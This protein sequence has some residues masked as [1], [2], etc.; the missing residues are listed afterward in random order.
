M[1]RKVKSI[2]ILC[3]LILLF[4]VILPP[5]VGY[6]ENAENADDAANIENTDVAEN[7]SESEEAT[8]TE[9]AVMPPTS[10]PTETE[11]SD[12]DDMELMASNEY[13]ELY[14]NEKNAEF[15]VKEKEN[16]YIWY[17]NPAERANDPIAN[18][19]NKSFLSA[20]IALTYFNEKGQTVKFDTYKDSVVEEQFEFEKIDNG[21]KVVY[22]LGVEAKGIEQI[23]EKIS[24][25]RF[26][27]LILDKLSEDDR[28][29]IEKRFKFVEEEDLYERR[30]GAFS[31]LT[32]ARTLQYFEEVGYTEEDLAFDNAEH[33]AADAELLAYPNFTL[34]FVVELDDDQLVVTIDGEE[35]E[36]EESYPI[37]ELHVLPFFGAASSDETGYMFVP[38]GSG[39]LIELNNGKGAY[40]PFS[41]KV[42]GIDEVDPIRSTSR[43]T[44][45]ES[46]RMPVFGLKQGDHA[47][48]GI[49]E[50]GDAVGKINAEVAD[51]VNSY[52]AV[53]SSFIFKQAEEITLQGGDQSNTVYAIQK[54]DFKETIKVRYAFLDKEAANY[55]GMANLYQQYLV[56][57]HQLEPLE[58][59]ED[60]P[61]YLELAGAIWKKKF[62][63]GIPYRSLQPL[64]TFEQ[65]EKIVSELQD[66]NVNN[67]KLRFTGWFNNGINHKIPT[68]VK[69]D[70]VLGGKKGLE[71]F[72]EFLLD[73]NV[74]L[75]PDVAFTNVYQNT[76][77]FVPTK[78]ASRHIRREVAERRPIN[79]ATFRRNPARSPY[80]LLSP[81]HLSRSVDG[82]I[83]D[84]EK[85]NI[86][87]VSL[88]DLGEK[89]NSD[90]REKKVINREQSKRITE[91]QLS[92]LNDKVPN[93]MGYGGN[94]L[95]FP[96]VSDL[97]NVPTTSSQF[98]ITDKSIPFYQM[99]IHGYINFA[100]E[101][102][103]LAVDQNIAFHTLKALE[104]GSNIYFSWFY[105]DGSMIKETEYNDL[106]SSNYK[107]WIDEATAMYEE[108]NSILKEVRDKPITS[109]EELSRGVFETTYGNDFSIIVNYNN[110][111]VDVDGMTIE[112]E[113]YEIR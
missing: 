100:G 60:I 83:S 62:F 10:F 6:A 13:L 32:L 93:M 92:K 101:P 23:P 49:I 56:D 89:I 65:G 17:S 64:T 74:E 63:L 104:T 111:S 44:I 110:Q 91:E 16:G 102:V 77:G 57:K 88:R 85:L 31:D 112:A 9:E 38:D 90:Y 84:Y 27:S 54:G 107:L 36:Y 28:R 8:D 25:E 41:E 82:F 50:E 24:K 76:F 61:F 11:I 52:N 55:T 80:Y 42:Y 35:L 86:N 58:A 14:F 19:E 26:H 69:V 7:E 106:I 46:I 29:D 5:S 48:F 105:E 40:E 103:N 68:K 97:I 73:N 51:R 43:R 79:P 3:C 75:Y 2:S 34:P 94:A 67:I 21:F 18:P 47:F 108:V 30:D 71:Q 66:N 70:R 59:G 81:D 37:H 22:T 113:S 15:A 4:V 45:S 95:L 98:N 109:H 1:T 96:Y 78:H 12:I 72:N 33:G 87:N 99:V 39:A 20:Q 53:S